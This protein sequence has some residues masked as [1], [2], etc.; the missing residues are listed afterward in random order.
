MKYMNFFENVELVQGSPWRAE[1]V[2]ILKKYEGWSMLK[3]LNDK[4]GAE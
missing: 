3:I 1:N 2:D 4:E